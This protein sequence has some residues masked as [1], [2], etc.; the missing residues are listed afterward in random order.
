MEHLGNILETQFS[1]SSL[2]Q[3]LQSTYLLFLKS[4]LVIFWFKAKEKARLGVVDLF[5]SHIKLPNFLQIKASVSFL[6]IPIYLSHLNYQIHEH[7]HR[8]GN[9]FMHLCGIWLVLVS[10]LLTISNGIFM[11]YI[12]T[13]N[14]VLKQRIT[15]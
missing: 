9:C 7:L 2:F 13:Y 1:I 4:C 5:F 12:L 14:Y 6:S 3:I 15:S 11:H 8:F 10:F